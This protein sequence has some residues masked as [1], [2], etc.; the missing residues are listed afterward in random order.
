VLGS[1]LSQAR[2]KQLVEI[3]GDNPLGQNH[4]S[5]PLGVVRRA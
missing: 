4:E 3:L 5:T 2:E 1:T